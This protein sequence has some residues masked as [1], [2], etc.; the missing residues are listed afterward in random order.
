MFRFLDHHQA[1]LARNLKNRL[2][3][4]HIKFSVMWDLIKPTT[5]VLKF[6]LSSVIIEWLYC[7]CCIKSCMSTVVKLLCY[8]SQGRWFDPRWCHWNFLLT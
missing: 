5:Q 3:V 6:C 4:V 2:H 1:I 7:L 8:K